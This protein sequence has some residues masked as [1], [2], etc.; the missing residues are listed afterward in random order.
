MKLFIVLAGMIC[1]LAHA[2]IASAEITVF[3]CHFAASQAAATFITIYDDGSP[4]RIGV[5]VGV[6]SKAQAYFD[7]P[8]GATV[9]VE[10]NGAGIPDTLT[11]INRDGKAVHSRHLLAVPD[12]L[13]VPSQ[14]VGQ[15]DRRAVR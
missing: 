10:F 12:G 5:E 13:F 2:R 3:A 8:T 7:R 15:C 6:G 9:V 14:T 4:S 1:G 11:T